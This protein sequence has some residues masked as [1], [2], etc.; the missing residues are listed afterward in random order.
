MVGQQWVALSMQLVF[1]LLG[2]WLCQQKW[3]SNLLGDLEI[4]KQVVSVLQNQWFWC[5]FEKDTYL[6]KCLSE[7]ALPPK[8][9]LVFHHFPFKWPI[10]WVYRYTPFSDIHPLEDVFLGRQF[11]SSGLGYLKLT[12]QSSETTIFTQN[13]RP[14]HIFPMKIVNGFP[15]EKKYPIYPLKQVTNPV[16][17]IHTNL[18]G[19]LRNL[20]WRYLPYIRPIWQA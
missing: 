3:F 12:S 20:N 10:L 2:S 7:N 11:S 15:Y 8:K 1:R 9:I 4:I 16:T 19:P 18:T 14:Q 17:L 6:P 5:N 13:G